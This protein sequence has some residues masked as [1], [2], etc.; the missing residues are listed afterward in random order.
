MNPEGKTMLAGGIAFAG[1]VKEAGGFPSNGYRILAA[2][3]T[4]TVIYSLGSRSKIEPIISGLATLTL[5]ASVM[6]YI[7]KLV[8]M[9]KTKKGKKNG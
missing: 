7:P 9:S 4:L 1:S 2:T 6:Y 5:L 8:G 3:F